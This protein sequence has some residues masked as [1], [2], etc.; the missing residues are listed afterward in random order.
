MIDGD[1]ARLAQVIGNLLHNAA[2]Y[3]EPGGRLA[4]DAA[5]EGA[6]A[7][8][9]VRDSGIG[10]DE[11]SIASIFE[12]FVQV[13]RS[14]TRSQAGLGVGLTL[15]RRL[16]ALHDGTITAYSEGLGQGSEFIVRVPLAQSAGEAPQP[17]TQRLQA[18]R[19]RPRR[20][21]LADDNVDFARSLA[22]VLERN[23]HEVRVV[24]DGA[25][26]LREVE[27]FRPDYA[28]L[29]IG[30][31]KVHGYELARRLRERPETAD[32]VLVAVTG[33]GQ[34]D[35]RRRAREAGFVRHLVKPVDPADIESIVAEG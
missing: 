34:E 35:D 4:I 19:D 18:R 15:A 24:H 7:A 17:G 33:W 21:L 13:D 9:R 14:L 29:D 28:F 25:E 6:D 3:T 5:R 12:M 22:T 20:I 1:R 2:K 27:T 11:R 32:C 23:G 10:L 30:M 16:V 26:A 31:P 8:V